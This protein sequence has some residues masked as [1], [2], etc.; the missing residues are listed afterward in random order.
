MRSSGYPA[1]SG[2]ARSTSGGLLAVFAHPDDEAFGVAG[3]LRR[4]TAAGHPAAVV[5]ATRG[6]A[7]EI[8][9]PR[10]ATQEMLGQVRERELRAACAAVG[11]NDVAFLGYQDGHLAE[12]DPEE[13]VKRIVRHIRTRRPAIVVTF[14]PNGIYGHLDHMAIH[15]LTLAAVVAAADPARFSDHRGSGLAP[16]RVS[17]V[18]YTAPSREDLVVRR[19]EMRQHGSDFLP[20]GNAATIP[21][22]EMGT[23]EAELTTRVVLTDT[24]FAAKHRAMEAH[25]TQMPAGGFFRSASPDELRASMGLETFVLAPPPISARDFPVPETD[26]FAGL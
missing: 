11:V 9:D 17:K 20:G 14:P 6:E 4:V 8:A 22:E 19:D 1:N 26:L 24:E 12:V 18:Y 10:L 15:Q 25:A 3:T 21:F 5:C 23:P 7:G 16:H 13:A 2:A